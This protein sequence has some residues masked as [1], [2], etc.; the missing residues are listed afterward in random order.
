MTAPRDSVRQLEAKLWSWAVKLDELAGK[1][2]QIAGEAGADLLR[3]VE[4]LSAKLALAQKRF[5][6]FKAAGR[7]NWERFRGGIEE[8]WDEFEAA[9]K[10][11]PR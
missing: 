5:N 4:D 11:E 2:H 3:R 9:L 7:E 1:A 6:E 10:S 8:A